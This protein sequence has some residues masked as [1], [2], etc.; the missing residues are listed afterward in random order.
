M[1]VVLAA[2]AA[3]DLYERAP[4]KL[5]AA[6]DGLNDAVL[7]RL[8]I[9]LESTSRWIVGHQF[10]QLTA[11]LRHLARKLQLQMRI[12]RRGQGFGPTI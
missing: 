7:V 3:S 2:I 6:T 11:Q 12:A 5:Q 9:D 8:R 4:L 10:T 1:R